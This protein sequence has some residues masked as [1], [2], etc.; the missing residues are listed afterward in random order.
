[1]TNS[2]NLKNE[3][4]S[5]MKET[6]EPYVVARRFVLDSKDKNKPAIDIL[7]DI[8]ID[9]KDRDPEEISKEIAQET[10]NRLTQQTIIEERQRLPKKVVALPTPLEGQ[11]TIACMSNCKGPYKSEVQESREYHIKGMGK[12]TS[13]LLLAGAIAQRYHAQGESKKVVVVDLDMTARLPISLAL[14]QFMPSALSI[15]FSP[16][17]EPSGVNVSKTVLDNLIHNKELRIDVLVTPSKKHTDEL[18]P[19]F[20]SEVIQILKSTHDVIILDCPANYWDSHAQMAFNLSDK[21]LYFSR[22]DLIKVEEMIIF[23][24]NVLKKN[25]L[26]T[27]VI[28]KE[29]LGIVVIDTNDNSTISEEDFL[30][31]AQGVPILGRILY[32]YEEMIIALDKHKIAD[33]LEIPSVYGGP[34]TPRKSYLELADNCLNYSMV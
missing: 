13:A 7:F 11:I 34:G 25:H 33:I 8:S 26:Y 16:G 17:W 15:K 23:I 22:Y 20:Y 4:R 14:G 5:R 29:K 12:T 24:S 1:M 19:T 18:G 2:P 6:E 9:T 21:I 31:A 30:R 27:D 28:L 10:S 32:I 3:I